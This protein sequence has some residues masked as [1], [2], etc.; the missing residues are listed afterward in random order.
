MVSILPDPVALGLN[1]TIPEI[2]DLVEALV[3]GKWTVV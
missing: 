3:R 1:P 2:I